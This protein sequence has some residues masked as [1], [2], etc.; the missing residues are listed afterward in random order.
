MPRKGPRTA[1]ASKSSS[2]KYGEDARNSK[3][4][5]QNQKQRESHPKGSLLALLTIP[6]SHCRRGTGLLAS[7]TKNKPGPIVDH[8][9][10]MICSSIPANHLSPFKP[11]GLRKSRKFH[12]C[13]IVGPSHHTQ[14]QAHVVLSVSLRPCELRGDEDGCH[15]PCDSLDSQLRPG[16]FFDLF[17]GMLLQKSSNEFK[18]GSLT[19]AL[20]ASY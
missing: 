17:A 14:I 13:S 5:A 20:E 2:A 15:Q 16:G 10:S 19:P 11:N 12:R 9:G 3:G 18:R 7:A 6:S 8:F 4:A 1:R